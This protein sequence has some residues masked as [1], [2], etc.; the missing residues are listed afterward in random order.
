M[1]HEL[2][3]QLA[4][5]LPPSPLWRP[6]QAPS[7]LGTGSL[8]NS[9][10]WPALSRKLRQLPRAARRSA[11]P[12]TQGMGLD[13]LQLCVQPRASSRQRVL[14]LDASL[15]TAPLSP[16]LAG[17]AAQPRAPLPIN[18]PSWRPHSHL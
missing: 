11:F 18:C 6:R 17:G 5:P 16:R 13:P 12:L 9:A 2:Q 14:P 1:S 15:G 7:F 3:P 10:P 8:A 4:W